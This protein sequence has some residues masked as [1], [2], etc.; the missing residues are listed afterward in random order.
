MPYIT[1]FG[2]MQK[3]S[4]PEWTI[5]A[6]VRVR[7]NARQTILMSKVQPSEERLQWFFFCIFRQHSIGPLIFIY[8]WLLFPVMKWTPTC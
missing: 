2:N 4:M 3:P 7:G 1:A 5:W 6:Q 8:T